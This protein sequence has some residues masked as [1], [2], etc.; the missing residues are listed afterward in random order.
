MFFKNRHISSALAEL[1][2]SVAL[3]SVEPVPLEDSVG[4]AGV[5]NSGPRHLAGGDHTTRR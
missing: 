3:G 1:I 5:P 2:R 4:A